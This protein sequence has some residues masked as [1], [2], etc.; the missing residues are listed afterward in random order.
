VV[1]L[2][3]LTLIAATREVASRIPSLESL[4]SLVGT[5]VSSGFLYLIGFLNFIVLLEIYR[6]FK[7]VRDRG[8]DES[9]INQA[10]LKRGFMN[11]YLGGLFRVVNTQYHMYPIGFLFGLGFDTASGDR[12]A[13]DLSRSVRSFPQGPPLDPR[14]IPPPLHRGDDPP[15]HD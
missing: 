6:V 15:G 1:I 14:C 5:M 2:L 9:Q 11:R 12:A 3:A 8:A 13:R 4:G 10:L 7:E